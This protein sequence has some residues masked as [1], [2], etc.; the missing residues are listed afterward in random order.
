MN[1]GWSGAIGLVLDNENSLT[2][3][4]ERTIAKATTL[5]S[6]LRVFHDE[7]SL[8]VFPKLVCIGYFSN[9]RRPL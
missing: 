8:S 7:L 9:G 5:I 6:K 1:T 3:G 4:V 2:E